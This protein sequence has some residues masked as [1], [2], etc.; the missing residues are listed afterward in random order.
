MPSQKI[1]DWDAARRAFSNMASASKEAARKALLQEGHYLRSK[2]LDGLKDQAP[3]GQAF[4][5]LSPLTLAAR[6]LGG[7]SGTKA[8]I[9]QGDLRNGITVLERTSLVFIGVPRTAVARDGGHLVDIAAV[10]EFGSKPFT[11]TITDKMRRWLGVLYK[12]AGIE[13]QPGGGGGGSA[14]VMVIR[15]PARP[16]I[17]PVF[18]R[19]AAPGDVKKRLEQRMAKMLTGILSK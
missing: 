17:R 14:G 13:R 3:G 16:F 4:K 11:I 5:P 7:F 6:R 9:R 1:G 10:H 18:N 8:L 19:D 12:E 15:I 2:M